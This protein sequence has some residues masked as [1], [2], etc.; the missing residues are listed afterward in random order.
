MGST[1]ITPPLLLEALR[2]LGETELAIALVDER[3]NELTAELFTELNIE[4]TDEFF[5][6]LVAT[7]EAAAARL[8]TAVLLNMALL[9]AIVLAEL[10]EAAALTGTAELTTGAVL[11]TEAALIATLD[12]DSGRAL[13]LANAALEPISSPSAAV[14]I[15]MLDVASAAAERLTLLALAMAGAWSADLGALLP[16]PPPPHAFKATTTKVTRIVLARLDNFIKA[17]CLV[18]LIVR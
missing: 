1:N 17:S 2:L 14:F 8:E 15:V 5:T 12:T 3:L 7:L 13:E 16:L 10:T 11:I 18:I 6:E 9:L 4:I